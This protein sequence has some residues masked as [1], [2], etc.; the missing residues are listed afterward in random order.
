MRTVLQRV[1][2]SSVTINGETTRSIKEGLLIL[3][4]IEDLD[5][6]EDI[7]WLVKK[8]LNL[9]IFSDSDDK[10]NLSIEDINGSLMVISQ[11]TLFASTKKGNRPSYLK[12]SKPDIAIPLYNQFVS[13]LRHHTTLEIEEGEFGA[14]MQI[15]L[16]NDGPVTIFID[17]K[18]K[19]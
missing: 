12:S 14:D 19:T 11:F 16:V 4:G 1:K 8:I 15:E 7:N 5:N 2:N 9:R 3:I 18:D 17:T 6:Q 13:T 10:M